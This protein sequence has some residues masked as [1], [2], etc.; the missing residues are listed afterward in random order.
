MHR[1]NSLIAVASILINVGCGGSSASAPPP[2][3][4]TEPAAATAAAAP[5]APA[6]AAAAPAAPPAAAEANPAPADVA[7]YKAIVDAPDRDPADRKIDEG[8]KPAELLAFLGIKPGMHVAEIGAA[9]GYTAEL[10]ARAVG[11]SGVVY[12]QNT[13]AILQRFAEKP[14][15][16]RL[17]K[18][19]MK[20]VVR[21][22]REFEDPLPKEA[23]D[24]D[25]V[26]IIL[27]YH[28]TVWQKVDRDKMNRAIFA[29]LK[30][31]GEY[32]VV[33]SR[34]RDG[35]GTADTQTLHRI[36]EKVVREEVTRAIRRIPAT[37]T[38]PQWPPV[39]GAAR[40]TASYSSSSNRDAER[41]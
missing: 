21:A 39:N 8:R 18:P 40:A 6:T 17:K 13:P 25:A 12:G 30:P 16:E 34:A 41:K 28:D 20:N 1:K 26:A 15:S 14:W 31:G 11:P 32:V 5:V 22:D 35:S 29:A 23:H 24:L 36:E 7:A 19:V 33:D 38:L 4:G 10:L 3:A 2:A 37:G 27:F 9:L